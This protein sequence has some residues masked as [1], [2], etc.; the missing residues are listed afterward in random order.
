MDNR[1]RNRILLTITLVAV[2]LLSAVIFSF[3]RRASDEMEQYSFGELTA[4]TKCTAKDYYDTIQTDKVILSAMADLIALQ[5]QDD[6]DA[7]LQIMN[8]CGAERTFIS[9]V[10]LLLPDGRMLHQDGTWYD[11]SALRSFEAE[12]ARGAYI[13]DRVYSFLA[14]DTL[15]VRNAVPVV[16]NGETVAMLY[17]VIPLEETSRS[18]PVE[19]YNGKAF[20]MIV[21][22]TSGDILLDTWHDALGSMSDP[23]SRKTLKGYSYEQAVDNISHGRSGDMRSVSQKTGSITYMHYEPVGISNWSVAVG[24]SEETALAETRDV[25]TT[26]YPMAFIVGV[27]FFA[28]MVYIIWYLMWSR[29]SLYQTSIKGQ[30]TGPLNRS[31][32]ERYLLKSRRRL[33]ASAA[34]IYVDVN[35]L[36]E[37]NNRQGHA[38]GDQMLRSVAEQLKKHFPDA[39]LFRIGG[40]EFVVFPAGASR[41]RAEAG[42]AQ[43]TAALAE[44]GFSISYG[45]AVGHAVMGLNDLVREADERMLEQKRAYYSEHDRREAR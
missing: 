38:A 26:L 35:G 8:S 32:Y 31:A 11:V 6:L 20:V 37:I 10:E 24:V 30:C 33:R 7:V 43:V 5:K 17:G 29:R 42:M 23:S 36:H 9:Y 34:C 41:E 45:L 19:P 2:A 28:Y 39:R 1:K 12:A 27:A 13:S 16:K 15:I 44:Q 25:V 14:P 3:V 40:D 4:A 21:D 22:G 18:F